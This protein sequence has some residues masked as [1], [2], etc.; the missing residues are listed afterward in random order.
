MSWPLGSA[1]ANG[2]NVANHQDQASAELLAAGL[3]QLKK[4]HLYCFFARILANLMIPLFPIKIVHPWT[5]EPLFFPE[6]FKKNNRI[7]R[8]PAARG[9]ISSNRGEGRMMQ[10]PKSQ[11]SL[12]ESWITLDIQNVSL[13]RRKV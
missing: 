12:L 13:F 6:N 10:A 5:E 8:D 2:G 11:S 7:H 4:S 3:P 9:G 1:L